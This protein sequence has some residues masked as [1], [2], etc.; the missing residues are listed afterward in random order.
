M[1]TW[2]KC[3]VDPTCCCAEF[4]DTGFAVHV[5]FED[6]GK[7]GD[8]DSFIHFFAEEELLKVTEEPLAQQSKP[9]GPESVIAFDGMSCKAFKLEQLGSVGQKPRS[10]A[11]YDPNSP[12]TSS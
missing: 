3:D 7:F 12:S 8:G 2:E 4:V 1:K 11:N 5:K 10:I 6:D 9:D